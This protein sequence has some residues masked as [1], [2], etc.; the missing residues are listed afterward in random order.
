VPLLVALVVLRTPR[1]YPILD[2]AQTEI[3]VRDVFTG[4]TPLIGLPGRIGT[5]GNQGSHPGPL[6]FWTLAPFYRLFGATSW[7]LQIASVAL[8]SI[9]VGAIAW[10]AY[11][12]GGIRLVVG[13][14]AVVALVMRA[15][16]AGT[17]TEAWN[18]HLP[19]LFWIVLLLA[20]WSVISD[21]LAM[22]PVA[23]FAGSFCA[24]THVPYL[25]LAGGMLAFGVVVA[26]WHAY[27]DAD[28]AAR[29]RF[30]RWLLIATGVGIAA[31]LAPLLQQLGDRGNLTLIWETF[32]D[33]SESTVG[34]RRGIEA[35]LVD[36]NPWTLVTKHVAE[37]PQTATSGTIVPGLLVLATWVASAVVAFRLRHRALLRLDA[38]LAV[39]LA[40][41]AVSTSR[42]FGVLWFYLV[43]CAW[44]IQALM[45]LAIGWTAAAYGTLRL[46]RPT[47]ERALSAATV[48]AA[49]IA[50]VVSVVFAVDAAST[51]SPNAR[52]S[53]TLGEVAGPTADAL[54]AG[55][56]PGGGRAGRYLVTWDDPVSIGAPGWGLMNELDRRGF[57]VG[58]PLRYEGGAPPDQVMSPEEPTAEVHLV[59]GAGVETWAARPGVEEVARF[60][61]RTPAQRAEYE[62]I[63]ARVVADL[64]E[65]GLDELVAPV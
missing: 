38:V 46:D 28:R 59:V 13:T 22:L 21:D 35:I 58:V 43:L 7:A 11:R 29:R 31:W 36:L 18:P 49:G 64:E 50:V 32:R 25:G 23:V 1:W 6:S 3:R 17:L 8:Q 41:G 48:A 10:I 12:R 45:L 34:A 54:D 30:L 26:G 20:V 61:P 39:A 51:D 19:L 44:G 37:R 55:A 60:D 4:D 5:F 2:M 52:L 33:P 53:R 57:E 9:A 56:G 63:R 62:R 47:R 42:I 16:G 40:L 15:Y 27:R 65:A 24:Q 14:L